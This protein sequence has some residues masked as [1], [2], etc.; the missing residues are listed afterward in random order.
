MHDLSTLRG[1]AGVDIV[2]LLVLASIATALQC[3]PN[4]GEMLQWQRDAGWLV[5]LLTSV[6][7]HLTHWSWDHFLWDILAF[8]GLGWTAIRLVPGRITSCLLLSTILIPLEIALF[9]PEFSTYRGLSGLDSALF[10]LL[11]AGLWRRGKMGKLLFLSGLT[12]FLGK[13]GYELVTG[14]TLFV[15]HEASGF[16]PVPSAHLVGLFC[17]LLAGN[18]KIRTLVRFFGTPPQCV[19]KGKTKE[20]E[21][22]P[23]SSN[24]SRS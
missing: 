3:F 19:Q 4:L 16:A 5:G 8:L 14:E 20:T 24:R 23:G 13:A 9:R 15:D 11:L 10:G 12:V 1:R 17:G 21:L 6:T 2:L 18:E 7:G 22:T